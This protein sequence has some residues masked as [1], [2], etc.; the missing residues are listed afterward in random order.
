M[1][2]DYKWRGNHGIGALYFGGSVCRNN[3]LA[4]DNGVRNKR[5]PFFV[6]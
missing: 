1:N 4:M 6:L 5:V 2:N 3:T